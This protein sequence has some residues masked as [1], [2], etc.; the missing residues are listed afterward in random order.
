MPPMN[1]Y[2]IRVAS[3]VSIVSS[4]TRRNRPTSSA[5]VTSL[6]VSGTR[7]AIL[8]CPGRVGRRAAGAWLFPVLIPGKR[9][10]GLAL[11]A[12]VLEQIEDGGLH[13]VSEPGID[14]PRVIAESDL[15]TQRG[16]DR[17]ALL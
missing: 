11:H 6:V 9:L 10:G 12:C 14:R 4:R 8:L 5:S 13:H 17:D 15:V 16:P 1:R 3:S 2:G 7:I